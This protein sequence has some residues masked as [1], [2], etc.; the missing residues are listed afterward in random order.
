MY[1]YKHSLSINQ[2]QLD[3]SPSTDVHV[4]ISNTQSLE[5]IFIWK[6]KF[7]ISSHSSLQAWWHSD[8][9]ISITVVSLIIAPGQIFVAMLFWHIS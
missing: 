4:L 6:I 8:M 5:M 9:D 2:K 1:A 7:Y 3:M